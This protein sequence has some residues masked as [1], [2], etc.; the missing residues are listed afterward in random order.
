[1]NTWTENR[2][3]I[4]EFPEPQKESLKN[5][6]KSQESASISFEQKDFTI[7]EILPT[8]KKSNVRFLKRVSPFLLLEVFLLALCPYL[9]ITGKGSVHS[10]WL[11]LFLFVFIEVNV[12]FTDFALWNYFNGKKIIRIWLIEVPL[13]FLI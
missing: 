4:E 13:A 1:M 3:L 6:T 12:M 5:K 11:L 10:V 8:K 7:S 2:K 9:I